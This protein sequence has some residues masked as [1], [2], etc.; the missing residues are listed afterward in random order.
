MKKILLAVAIVASL[1]GF[2]GHA[3][4]AQ[5]CDSNAIMWCGAT[6][7]AQFAYRFVGGDGHN[8][9]A[10]LQAIY[11]AYSV[12]I[13]EMKLASEGS[14]TKS[15]NV[16]VNGKTVATGAKSIGREY[17]PGSTKQHGVWIRS[18]QTSF[19][20]DSLDAFVYMKD[21]VFQWAV[22]KSCG[23]VV[24]ATPVPK[25]KPK[26]VPVTPAKPTPT[27]APIPEIVPSPAPV[28]PETGMEL[29][30][31]AAMGTTSV[32]YGLRGYLRSKKQ[33]ASALRRKA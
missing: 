25:P 33:L 14:V 27:P 22:L 6:S 26:P 16:I 9:A 2:S 29:P 23:N 11:G 15:G 13:E 21:G 7:K 19:K 5:D 17:M 8:S 30:I 4:A 3:L 31:A 24:V 10:N 12:S 1:V 28:L 18:T 32:G 20:S